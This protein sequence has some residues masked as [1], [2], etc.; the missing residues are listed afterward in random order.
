VP[1][2]HQAI[3]E[4]PLDITHSNIKE[5]GLNSNKEVLGPLLNKNG[6]GWQAV[7]QEYKDK[8]N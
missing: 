4:P 6:N 7:K 2:A 8:D 5:E 1:F 3:A